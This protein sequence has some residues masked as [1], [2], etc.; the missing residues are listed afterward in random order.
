MGLLLQHFCQVKHSM[1]ATN[2]NCGRHPDA[3]LSLFLFNKG[4]CC[5]IESISHPCVFKLREDYLVFF[6]F[7]ALAPAFFPPADFRAASSSAVGGRGLTNGINSLYLAGMY[8]HVK[9]SR[10]GR[11]VRTAITG[12]KHTSEEP[13]VQRFRRLSRNLQPGTTPEYSK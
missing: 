10:L 9:Y 3:I 4:K 6:G 11:D 8:L 7:E 12:A 5:S 13:Q 1:D 2:A